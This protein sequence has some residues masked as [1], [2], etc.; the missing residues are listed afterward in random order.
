MVIEIEIY[1]RIDEIVDWCFERRLGYDIVGEDPEN[2]FN[3]R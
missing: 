1:K 2:T 3:G